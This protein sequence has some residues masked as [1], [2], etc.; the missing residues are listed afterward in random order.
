MFIVNAW[1]SPIWPASITRRVSI[2]LLNS[3]IYKIAFNFT[4]DIHSIHKL[5]LSNN[6]WSRFL[7]FAAYFR[8]KKAST[9]DQDLTSTR[10]QCLHALLVCCQDTV[11]I[12]L[13][14]IRI[15]IHTI[16]SRGACREDTPLYCRV[17]KKKNSKIKQNSQNEICPIIKLTAFSIF[18][19]P[20]YQLIKQQHPI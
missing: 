3:R 6:H 4:G 14:S 7:S 16:H 10:H 2:L 11:V 1:Q 19:L 18:P 8:E 15:D 13:L 5:F 12:A 9:T 17:W 20:S